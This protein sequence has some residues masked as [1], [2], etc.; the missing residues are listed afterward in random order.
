VTQA[1]PTG[2]MVTSAPV[3]WQGYGSSPRLPWEWVISIIL[4]LIMLITLWDIWLIV[5]YRVC[6][7][8]V[9]KEPADLLLRKPVG[10]EGLAEEE[11]KRSKYYL[12]EKQVGGDVFMTVEKDAG[13]VLKRDIRYRWMEDS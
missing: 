7:M 2:A 6:D 10:V 4:G 5:R 13:H 1:D 8:P 9:V 11:R 12:R 3:Q